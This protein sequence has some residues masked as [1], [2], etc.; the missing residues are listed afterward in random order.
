MCLTL[1]S[2]AARL[3]TEDYTVVRVNT[4][5]S[6]SLKVY[7][8]SYGNAVQKAERVSYLLVQIM[9]ECRT[10]DPHSSHLS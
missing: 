4:D 9:V 5:S 1:V 7:S 6:N 8:S 10:H 3:K 2:V